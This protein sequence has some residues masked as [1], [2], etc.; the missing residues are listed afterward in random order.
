MGLLRS[1]AS[2]FDVAVVRVVQQLARTTAGR[3]PTQAERLER[4]A[5]TAHIYRDVS[6]ESFFAPPPVPRVEGWWV[7]NLPDGGEVVD[8]TWESGWVPYDVEGRDAYLRF[9]ENRIAHARLL[10]HSSPA[11]TILCLHGYRAG[12]HRLEE[13][14]WRARWLYS[15]LGLDVALVTLPFHALR[16]PR[17]RFAPVFPSMRT[18]RTVEG[19]GQAVWD[20]RSLIA[21]LRERGAIRLGVAGMSLGGYT[22]ALLATV[23]PRLDWAILFIPLADLTD[24]S[25]EHEALR[26]GEIPEPLREAGKIALRLVRPLGRTPL[27]PGDRMLVVAAEGDRITATRT[28][29]ERLAAHFNAPLVAFPGGHLLQFGRRAGL[30]AMERLIRSRI[31]APPDP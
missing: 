6:P 11:P 16:A 4:M 7:R 20:V 31:A 27:L 12:I 23:E 29:A 18:D 22:A 2:T 28:H 8:L 5:R 15:R 19:F 24:V 13:V 3:R 25:A 26:G 17:G 10:R 30:K 9:E 21:W 14:A 1:A